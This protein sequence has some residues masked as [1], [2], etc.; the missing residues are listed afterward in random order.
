MDDLRARG[1]VHQVADHEERKIEALLGEPQT[2]YAGFDP[3]AS[4]LHLGN[5]IPLL[6]LRRFQEAGHRVIA[7]A[8]GATGMIGDPSGKSQE[9]NLLDEEQLRANVEAIRGQ[10]ERLLDFSGDQALLVDNLDWT[11]DVRYLDFLRD[12]GK[13]F[14]VNTMIR[15]DSVKGRLERDG[16][17]ISYTEF[18]YMLLQAHDYLHLHQAHG[19]RLQI[20][21]SD[22]WG[23]ITA[24]I[25]LIRRRA[26][27]KA[28]GVTCPLLL[29]SDGSKFG[30]TAAGA[31]WLDPALT[32]PFA[33]RQFW[34][35]VP[36][37]QVISL[38]N[39]FTFFSREEIDA[40]AAGVADKSQPG[41]AQRTLAR[42]MTAL[43][44]GE[45]EAE[46]VERAAKVLFAKNADFSQIPAEYLA[47]AFEGAPVTD[48]PR[49]RFSGDG[50][51]IV[52]LLALAVEEGGKPLSKSKARKLVQ[53]GSIS[54]GG[55]KVQDLE[56][57]VTGSDL[58]HDQWVVL[59]KGKRNYFL[60]RA[61]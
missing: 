37:D 15:K 17:G 44:H 53:Q 19:C 50:T 11:R 20:G 34:F 38:L 33:F 29:N 39:Y 7:L 43:V 61:T 35:K 26:G 47:D 32:S 42:S 57:Q 31:V 5:L 22:Q 41:E 8:G 12:V 23:N 18:S 10:L 45:G 36:D 52:D 1:L 16:E 2:V 46:K 54:L 55:A 48:L 4:S 27:E 56:R 13:H 14:T 3:T 6:G 51:G 59:R 49:D 25:E 28:Y 40:L 60:V 58:L 24:G 30:K 21:G 9:R